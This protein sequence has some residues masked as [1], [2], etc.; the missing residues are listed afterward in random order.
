MASG[1]F[2]L[3]GVVGS[4]ALG[5]SSLAAPLTTD[6]EMYEWRS[7]I[8][9]SFETGRIYRARLSPEVFDGFRSFPLDLRVVDR[10]G[11]DWPGLV[12][13]RSDLSG[14]VPVRHT[15]LN[16]TDV[17]VD[18]GF[19]VK[20]FQIEPGRDE[21][22]PIHNRVIV[23]AGSTEQLRRVEVWG[24]PHHDKLVLLGSG[25]VV[26]Q[27]S[28][29]PLRNRAIDYP[30][31][32]WPLVVVRVFNDVRHP[33]A[34]LDWR[35]TEIVRVDRDDADHEHV[36]LKRMEAP[37]DEIPVDGV[38]AMFLDAGSRNRPLLYLTFESNAT[39]FAIPLRVFGRNDATNKWRWVADGGIHHLDGTEQNRVALAKS[40][41]R[42]YKIEFYYHDQK[43]PRIKNVAASAMPYYLVFE[44]MSENKPYLFFGAPRY[45][46]DMVHPLRRAAAGN[47]PA[48]EEATLSK[49]H[50]NP[51][52]V[53]STLSDY[54]NTLMRFGLGV[55]VLLVAIFTV[56][57][58]RRRYF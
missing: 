50:T 16:R 47:L 46:L 41:Y 11:V 18:P 32:R 1:L 7:S 21:L 28:P 44:A 55:V 43:L 42:F 48:E 22:I 10:E 20:E 19:T 39:E 35:S 30:D 17:T 37:A 33:E 24:G 23:Q 53:A 45:N 8:S 49:R 52:R 12:W 6:L 25:F 4:M 9:G 13:S 36:D 34:V 29:A 14:V 27:K 3:G 51:M 31:S 58:I 2:M 38:A 40:D 57:V 5:L 26:E 56:R 15:L 54:R